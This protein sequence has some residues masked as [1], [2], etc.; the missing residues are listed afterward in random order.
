V[1]SYSHPELGQRP[2]GLLTESVTTTL[3]C[4]KED[5][6]PATVKIGN[7]AWLGELLVLSETVVQCIR[8]ADLLT[9]ELRQILYSETTYAASAQS[10]A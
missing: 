9:P 8:V 10:G 7:A 6:Q 2:L 4:S 5:L 1:V 3:K